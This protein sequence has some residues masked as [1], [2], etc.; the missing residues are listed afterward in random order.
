ME[1]VKNLKRTSGRKPRKFSSWQEFWEHY[2]K[3]PFRD[4]SCAGC[5]APAVVGA[6]VFKM[7]PEAT[8][9]WYIVPL[10]KSCNKKKDAF[11]VREY[12]LVSLYDRCDD[13]DDWW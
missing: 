8:K 13:D 2:K 3:H 12:D 11:Y 7:D 5:K 1:E 6:H 4:C 10:C 9:E